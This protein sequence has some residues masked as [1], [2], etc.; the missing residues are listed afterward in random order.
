[1]LYLKIIEEVPFIHKEE[2]Y[3]AR[4]YI[5]QNKPNYIYGEIVFAKS[6][7][8]PKNMRSIVREKLKEYNVYV[9]SDSKSLVTHSAVR[10]FINCL[11]H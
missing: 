3:F 7:K 6:K 5:P 2:Q 8:R 4:L 11:K 1:M 10:T 9:P